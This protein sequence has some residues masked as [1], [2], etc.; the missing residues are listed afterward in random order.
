MTAIVITVALVGE[1]RA[2]TRE[3]IAAVPAAD[4]TATVTM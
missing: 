1:F 2:G 3:V 4:C